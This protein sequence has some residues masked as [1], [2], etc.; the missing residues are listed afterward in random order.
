[1]ET[2][3]KSSDYIYTQSGKQMLPET[4]KP[5]DIVLEDIAFGLSRIFRF[6]GQSK[7]SVLRHSI[8]MASCFDIPE[9]KYLALF[10][11]APEAYLMDVPVPLKKF[12]RTDWHEQYQRI[13]RLIFDKFGV[14]NG[15]IAALEVSKL[16]KRIVE[17][18]M[19]AEDT[20]MRYPDA[21]RM[22]HAIKE[23]LRAGYRW[24]LHDKFLPVCWL[25]LVTEMALKYNY[26]VPPMALE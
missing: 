15:S 7:I 20:S 2:I 16:D 3:R 18:E 4:I 6:N 1:M 19:E 21:R 17:Y 14:T 10:H 5:Q 24:D 22:P 26:F 11:D 9:Y 12:M 23:E 25:D 8:G 13:E